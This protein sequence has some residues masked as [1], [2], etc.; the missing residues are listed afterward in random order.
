[1]FESKKAKNILLD[2]LHQGVASFGQHQYIKT[3]I[4]FT[5]N[6]FQICFNPRSSTS[7][8]ELIITEQL[9][10][11]EEILNL[12]QWKNLSFRELENFLRDINSTPSVSQTNFPQTK[13][14]FDRVKDDLLEAVLVKKALEIVKQSI[15]NISE[16]DYIVSC[17]KIAKGFSTLAAE[18]IFSER[19]F[20]RIYE[21]DNISGV[22]TFEMETDYS[23][24]EFEVRL[25]KLLTESIDGVNKVKMVARLEPES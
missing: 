12:N 3:S 5:L 22:I 21:Y 6:N 2:L 23:V 7:E 13:V 1:M 14:L 8:D 15:G 19:N 10:R 25:L 16:D 18:G 17:Q 9:L 11:F 24:P 20:F 4:E